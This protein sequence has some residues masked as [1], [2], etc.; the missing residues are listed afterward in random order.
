MFQRKTFQHLWEG[1]IS[2]FKIIGN[3]YFVGCFP[4]STH[5]IDTGDGLILIDP[6][7]T[8]T[9][10]LVI[11]SIYQLGY[12]PK[13]IRY[14]INTHWHGDHTEASAALAH[15]SGA[16]N[17]I[18]EYDAP[19]VKTMFTPDILI[20]DGDTLTLGNTT[21]RFIYTPG[22]TKGCISFVFDTAED[23]K[24]YHVG[25]FGGAG[26]NTLR[27]DHLSHDGCREDYKRS[28]EKLKKEKVNVFIGNHVWNN[29]TENKGKILRETGVNK[30][31]DE[32]LWYEFLDFCGKRLEEIEKSEDAQ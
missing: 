25:M 13:D 1:E 22:H 30:F 2:P 16:K 26:A 32:N 10:F 18:G 24:T 28:L 20:H 7:Y 11:S 9:F 12:D 8:E 23:G 3:V 14:I 21:I 19:Y 4:A 17:L 6:G 31:V 27:K 15:F 29:D 5:L